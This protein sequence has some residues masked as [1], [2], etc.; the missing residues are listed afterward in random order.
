MGGPI[1]IEI[2][3]YRKFRP[4]STKI[5]GHLPGRFSFQRSPIPV[6]EGQQDEQNPQNAKQ[7]GFVMTIPS[8]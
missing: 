7:S 8:L 5:R 4:G 1:G 3:V 6:I 2:P